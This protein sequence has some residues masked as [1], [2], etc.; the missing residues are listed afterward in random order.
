MNASPTSG[1]IASGSV[2]SA[3]RILTILEYLARTGDAAFT[4]LVRDLEIPNSSGHQLLQTGVHAGF[5][6]FD[7]TQR[8]F[9][10]GSRVWEIAQAYR[11][12]DDLVEVAR[13]FMVELGAATK[14]TVQLSRLSGRHNIYL[15]IHESPHVMKLVTSVGS[16]LPAHA[17]GLGKVLLSG[18]PQE[19]VANRFRDVEL[20]RFTNN[21]ITTVASLQHELE[22]IRMQGFGE[23]NEEYVI[24]CRCIA[25]PIRDASGNV[26]AAM[27]VS[28]PTPRFD[29]RVAQRISTELSRA[30]RQIELALLDRASSHLSRSTF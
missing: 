10:L 20:E 14:E 25:M 19:E 17:T 16:R 12:H 23:D 26:T 21:T 7:E 2:K 24:G 13:P 1:A 11:A 4:Q 22:H 3:D 15:A 8:V 29:E 27:S 30:T 5:I 9:R 28:V 18:L 6:E